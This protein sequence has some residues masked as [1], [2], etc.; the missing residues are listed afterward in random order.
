[1]D[2]RQKFKSNIEKAGVKNNG[3]VI[4]GVS[5][6]ID[7]V[8]MLDLFINSKLNLVVAHLNHGVR[9]E[10]GRDESLVEE[11]AAKNSLKFVSHRIDKPTGGN[12]EEEMRILRYEFLSRVAKDN[13]AKYIALAHNANDQ[14]ET[15][16]LNILRGSGPAGLAGMKEVSGKV[17]RPLLNVKREEI[18]S[19]ANENKLEWTEDLTNRDT[20]Y[21]RNY[22]RHKIFPLLTETNPSWLDAVNRMSASQREIDEHLKNEASEYLKSPVSELKKLPKPVL[23]EVFGLRY[24]QKKGN[25]VDLTLRNLADLEKLIAE[26][27]GTKRV[28]LPGKISA[29]RRYEI[30]DFE[31]KNDYN[32]DSP[33][34]K[35]LK[36]GINRFG[37]WQI[38]VTAGQGKNNKAEVILTKEQFSLVK[39]RTRKP[40]DLIETHYGHKKLQDLFVDAKINKEQRALWPVMTISEEV[41]WVPGLAVSQ[42]LK[43]KDGLK[44]NAKEVYVES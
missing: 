13:N 17:I 26:N 31:A 28:E 22:L 37:T 27:A 24:E 41:I 8:V 25:R 3:T 19:Y 39:V 20:L 32:L 29:V 42:T 44:I 10:A 16:F 35:K 33:S 14:A 9:K 5:G 38:E 23:Y 4:L 36:L 12:L 43:V 15:I 11:L 30:L 40:G 6:G 2:I 34:E 1:V 18:E 21:Q 7:S